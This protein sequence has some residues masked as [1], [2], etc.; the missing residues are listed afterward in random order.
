MANADDAADRAA[1]QAE[2]LTGGLFKGIKPKVPETDGG[3]WWERLSVGQSIVML[4]SG[5]NLLFGLFGFFATIG[6]IG[7]L[8]TFG[9][10]SFVFSLINL[11]IVAF[12]FYTSF[13]VKRVRRRGFASL[14]IV[15][16]AL[17]FAIGFV[18]AIVLMAVFAG[19]FGIGYGGIGTAFIGIFWYGAI[20]G[21]AILTMSNPQLTLNN[22]FGGS[23]T[24][25][26]A[27]TGQAAQPAPPPP[28]TH[29]P[30]IPAANIY[31][32][33]AG[34]SMGPFDRAT[35]DL[36]LAA[37]EF[38]RDDLVYADNNQWVPIKDCV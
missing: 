35:F 37:G 24:T 2:K 23:G 16:A 17:L 21:G 4:V 32:S 22:L 30:H 20:V 3:T 28:S 19:G 38:S 12:I 18:E 10:L 31:V 14:Q 29:K 25:F 36:K 5:L 8:G 33:K 13:E 11:L 6:W 26:T 1:A 9:I 34:A 15:L 7:W 27:S